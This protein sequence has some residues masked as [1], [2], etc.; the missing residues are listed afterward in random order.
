MARYARS[1][2]KLPCTNFECFFK[3]IKKENIM[4][5]ALVILLALT[6]VMSMMAIA[7]IGVAAEDE[8][9]V[10]SVAAD[11]KPEGTAIKT[12]EEF[13]AMDP[14]GTYYLANNITISESYKS[15]F[16]GTFDGNGKV[17]T[18]TVPTFIEVNGTIK[19]LTVE[20]NISSEAGIGYDSNAVS[21]GDPALNYI[22]GVACAAATTTST[23][24]INVCNKASL[25]SNVS[26]KGGIVGVACPTAKAEDG[27]TV[28]FT[29]C[30]NYGSIIGKHDSRTDCDNGG[31]LAF[32]GGA[33]NTEV[34][35]AYFT[36]CYNYATINAGGRPGGIGGY[37]RV[38]V[39]IKNC[40][41]YGDILST[42]NYCG[43]IVG[44]CGTNGGHNN[45]VFT[46]SSNSGDISVFSGQG[47]G[48]VGYSGACDSYT[49]KNCVNNGSV[50][51]E[52]SQATTK[53][54]DLAGFLGNMR[55]TGSDYVDTIYFENCVNNGTIGIKGLVGG[56]SGN[57][58]YCSGF[59]NKPRVEKSFTMINCINNGEIYA[60]G[61][62]QG[63]SNAAG[64]VALVL[65]KNKTNDGAKFVN[66]VNN[67]N[68]VSTGKAGGVVSEVGAADQYGNAEF[69]GCG[70]NGNVLSE[71]NNAGGV[72]CYVYGT[73]YEGADF[74]YCFNT[75]AVESKTSYAGGILA[76][77]NDY[78]VT[79]NMQY[80]YS[81]G[82][83]TSGK[84]AAGDF[85]TGVVDGAV[86]AITMYTYTN[87]LGN[88]KY[89]VAPADGKVTIANDVVT[90]T[91][92]AAYNYT[93]E[94]V[95]NGET[96]A[97]AKRYGYTDTLGNKW[98]FMTSSAV[99]GVVAITENAGAAPTIVCGGYTLH[100]MPW[101]VTA[102]TTAEL[103][104]F[105]G[106]PSATAL[107]WNNKGQQ[108]FS[109]NNYVLEGIATSA[110]VCGVGASWGAMQSDVGVNYVKEDAFAS[111]EIAYLL[112]EAV[113]ENVFYQNLNEKL[114]T[115][116]T[117]PTT[118]ATHAKVVKQGG[119][120]GNLLFE[121]NA[122]V[123]PPTGDATV[124]VVIAL[125][126]ST[127]SLAALAV[128]KK[129]KEN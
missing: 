12:A 45:Y 70:N 107:M 129:R 73:Q 44:R 126:V 128:V 102:N 34:T 116:D 104:Q 25:A 8:I 71:T 54:I 3:N 41:N 96:L 38:S 121:E 30:A 31:I 57:A 42:S 124:Y 16:T 9:A 83:V 13:A 109:N 58:R 37:L 50:Y 6:M 87:S 66:C 47:A 21:T 18:T 24:F 120:Y 94:N 14:A 111:G 53:N 55:Q 2:E 39:T 43:G 95:V 114:F 97:G 108:D 89:F 81:A 74:L 64:L 63:G 17:I 100:V 113:G 49:F 15:N 29:D 32:L 105:D 36:N 72:I 46:D 35:Y 7:P 40:H 33:A 115:V 106:N 20:G 86:K 125:A 101:N 60:D 11:Y 110:Y 82:K 28:N 26:A 98:V 67:G 1:V 5:K 79:T 117:Y 99:S 4:K 119:V 103:M 48:F 62:T 69:I 23:Y 56:Q 19:N 68:V 77:S 78:A 84:A 52:K 51:A 10:G 85:G 122:D 22:A 76:Y 92:N 123:T 118:D 65:F 80:C 90:F 27:I 112:N 88:T 61:V 75:G 93:N 91:A 127:V 59:V